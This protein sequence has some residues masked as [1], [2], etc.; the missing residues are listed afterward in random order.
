MKSWISAYKNNGY[1]I[2]IHLQ[3]HRNKQK[4]IGRLRDRVRE[5][6]EKDRETD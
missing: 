6:R 1:N 3:A 4:G 2:L 5:T